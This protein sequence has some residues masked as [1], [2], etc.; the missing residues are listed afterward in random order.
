MKIGCE[1][2]DL[3]TCV[4]KYRF[5]FFHQWI[6]LLHILTANATCSWQYKKCS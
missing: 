6:K 3:M 1:Q 2:N 5:F 4:K